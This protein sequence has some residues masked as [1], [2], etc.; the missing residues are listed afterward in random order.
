MTLIKSPQASPSASMT[1]WLFLLA[2]DYVYPDLSFMRL[3]L[4][5]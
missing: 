5:H 1:Y 2:L 4:Q 3:L